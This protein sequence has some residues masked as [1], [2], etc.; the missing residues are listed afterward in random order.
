MLAMLK[1]YIKSKPWLYDFLNS[2]RPITDDVEIWLDG[3]TKNNRKPIN[4]IQ[5]GASDGLR[6]DPFRRFIIRDKWNGIFVEPLPYVFEILKSNYAYRKKQNLKFV[7]AA[8][9][10]NDN[11]HIDIWSYSD[12]FCNSLSLEGSLFYLRK[13]SLDKKHV[14]SSLQSFDT[15]DDKIEC[16]RVKCLSINSLVEEYWGNNQL[17]II[18]IDAEGH[19]DKIVRTIDFKKLNPKAILFE[20]HNLGTRKQEIHDYLSENGYTVSNVG[21]DSVAIRN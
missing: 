6:W 3:F 21:G 1:D 7:N 10:T 9:S 19:D 2:K 16:F 13:S 17:D 5:I 8:I 14:E 12:D 18:L 15:I 20:S 4:F 11:D